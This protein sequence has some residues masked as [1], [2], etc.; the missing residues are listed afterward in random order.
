MN[1]LFK[2][3]MEIKQ[4][5][6]KLI[7]KY[8]VILVASYL[9]SILLSRYLWTTYTAV[10]H[11]T[12]ELLCIFMALSAFHIVWLTHDLNPAVNR[13]L[14]YGFLAVA[15]FDVMHTL[16][17]PL[18][19]LFP[20]H[21]DELSTLFWL[22]SRLTEAIILF[23]SSFNVNCLKNKWLSISITLL[24]AAGVSVLICYCTNFVFPLNS[25][26][27]I[28][29]VKIIF[30]YHIIGISLLSLLRMRKVIYSKDMQL[31]PNILIAILLFIPAE[32]C[33]T[34]HGPIT[35]TIKLEGHILKVIYYYFLLKGIF[36][37]AVFL[38]Y[39]QLKKAN[40]ELKDVKDEL[41]EILNGLPLALIT[42]NKDHRITFVNKH[43]L[44]L[45]ECQKEDLLGL[46][47]LQMGVKFL[48]NKVDTNSMLECI[49]IN[50]TEVLNYVC[51]FRTAKGKIRMLS[52]NA[53]QYKHGTLV[54]YSDAKEEQE[55]NHLRLQTVTI[56]NSLSNPVYITDEHF[57]IIMFNKAF[58]HC[59]EMEDS[60]IM[61]INLNELNRI[62]NFKICN[63]ASSVTS[64]CIPLNQT[65]EA[66]FTTSKGNPK[67]ILLHCSSITNID[68]AVI[69]YIGV[70]SDITAVKE[71]E[72]KI[73]QQEKLAIMGQM[74]SGIVHETKNLLASVKGYCQL[75]TSKL[76][77]EEL[78]KFVNRIESITNDVN[79]VITDFLSLAKPTQTVMDICSINEIIDSI[80][81]LLESPS[82]IRG[83]RID[84]NLCEKDN[85]IKADECQIKQVI[86]NMAKNAIEAM[87][88]T[89]NPRLIIS[90]LYDKKENAMK[91]ILSDNGK[92]IPEEIIGKLGTPFFTTKDTGTGLGLSVCFNILE[93]H[94]GKVDV[95]SVVGKGTTFILS[96]PCYDEADF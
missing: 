85:D 17:F 22:L 66:T 88:E 2:I 40:T 15:I 68:D 3:P 95:H 51:A 55:L 13:I 50:S 64:K 31:N 44:D 39:N 56:L 32:L 12:L 52:V 80:R 46:T 9:V 62:M 61:G 14:G 79:R 57:R 37:T 75:L 20:N 90:T 84:I 49:R 18:L 63:E 26:T 78:I 86:L 19:K 76:K 72:R 91:V 35:E 59:I 92:G 82:F 25:G 58:M 11:T 54:S 42:F 94:G 30:E 60:D 38:P 53:F 93:A 74:G 29:Q 36:T 45:L 28:T 47:A 48:V 77:E 10:S 69:G 27:Q 89:I 16:Y 65:C 6:C 67:N 5:I 96:F 43:A 7:L 4:K 1:D 73:Q 23:W 71:Q 34:L 8:I 70:Y 21:C 24:T 87:S 83:I 41:K 33:L 81:Y